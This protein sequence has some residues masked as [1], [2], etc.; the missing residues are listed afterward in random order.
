[1]GL[2]KLD[3]QFFGSLTCSQK[4]IK[5]N[6]KQ[7][8]LTKGL[9]IIEKEGEKCLIKDCRENNISPSPLCQ[10]HSAGASKHLEKQEKSSR[11]RK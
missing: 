2:L 1:L 4:L 8:T 7:L 5:I 10:G 11:I 3:L 6:A 9:G